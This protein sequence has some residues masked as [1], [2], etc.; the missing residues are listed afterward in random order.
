MAQIL[1]TNRYEQSTRLLT[2]VQKR[3][4]DLLTLTK[5][6]T[7]LSHLFNHLSTLLQQQDTDIQLISAASETTYVNMEMATQE[8]NRAI[9]SAKKARKRRWCLFGFVVILLGVGVAL[10]MLFV[11]PKFQNQN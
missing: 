4:T 10:I 1:A 11:V 3:H 6:L 7:S 5:S 8:L 9:K 2:D